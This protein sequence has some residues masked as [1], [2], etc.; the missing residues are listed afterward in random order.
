MTFDHIEGRLSRLRTRMAEEGTDV[1]VVLAHENFNGESLSY[2][3]GFR[4]SSG[5]AVISADEAL[6]VTDGRYSLQAAEQ[7]P[8][9]VVHQ[10]QKLLQERTAEL[11]RE[12]KW[13]RGGYEGE[14]LVVS[15][16]RALEGSLSHWN[17]CSNL[18]PELRRRKDDAEVAAIAKAAEIA[19]SAYEE[20]LKEVRPGMSENEFNALLEYLVRKGGAESGW[21][22]GKFIVASGERGALPHGRASDRLF[23][24][25]D[26]V[27]VDFGATVDGYVSDITRNFCLGPMPAKGREIEAALLEAAD[28]A[29]AE[30]RPGVE[31]RYVDSVARDIL[32][33]KGWGKYFIH[34]LGHGLGLEVHETPRLSPLSKDVLCEGDVVTVEP[35][36]Y[37][38]GWGGM[39]IEDDYLVTASGAVCISGCRGREA[40]E[41]PV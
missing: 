34:S 28:A 38:D 30:I 18:L 27:T 8:F 35:G 20:A 24:R 10:G 5:A 9:E 16:Y 31:G 25:G 23:Q 22:G 19:Y 7:S 3:S 32:G 29:V 33:E 39:R 41:I 13:R 11:L 15:V 6:L 17:D 36:I 40:V 12:R 37:I 1:M 26:M 21:Q 14:R 4:G 2:I